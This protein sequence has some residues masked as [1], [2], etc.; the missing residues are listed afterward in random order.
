MHLRE[1][2]A[3]LLV[4]FDA[5]LVDASVTAAAER[6]GRSPSAISHALAKLREIFDDELFVRAGQRLVPTAKARELETT[7]HVVIAGM[8]SLLRT[9]APFDPAEAERDFVLIASETMEVTLLRPL[10]DIL[11]A[12][13]PG[14]SVSRRPLRGA[15]DVEALRASRAHLLI[16][17]DGNELDT[18]D[19][20][21]SH[22]FD[23]GLVTLA[24][25]GHPLS[26]KP[27][28]TSAFAE[29]GHIRVRTLDT[30][31]PV[32]AALEGHGVR[33]NIR[34]EASSVYAALIMAR[35]TGHLVSVPLSLAEAVQNHIA[36]VRI[37]QP[38]RVLTAPVRLYWH[39]SQ[40]RDEAHAWLI[41]QIRQIVAGLG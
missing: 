19:I 28:T 5:L 23:D 4:V 35:E 32:D 13:A 21:S 39:T 20:E 24:R 15:S 18:P 30:I 22:L 6:L 38:F 37:K 2:N 31:E 11:A 12:A 3:N 40:A 16:A 29:A 34:L 9:R 27:P 14:I 26:E 41:G 17:G 10:L 25:P 7:V 36:L 33:C 8:E 1:I